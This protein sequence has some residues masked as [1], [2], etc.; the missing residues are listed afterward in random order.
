MQGTT[1]LCLFRFSGQLSLRHSPYCYRRSGQLSFWR[2]RGSIQTP[3]LESLGQLSQKGSKKGA[4]QMSFLTSLGSLLRKVSKKRGPLQSDKK[5]HRKSENSY[6]FGV[7]FW[8][9]FLKK[10]Y[11]KS[12]PEPLLKQEHVSLD[13]GCPRH[14]K[15]GF[16][17]VPDV[18]S[19]HQ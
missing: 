16:R 3:F 7:C 15:K 12:D 1:I 14:R 4:I 8:G 19:T 10:T 6:F 17:E 2:F 5:G 18:S 13:S 11:K 9:A